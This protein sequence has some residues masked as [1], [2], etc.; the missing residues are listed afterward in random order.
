M[1]LV[2]DR[3]FGLFPIQDCINVGIS[4]LGSISI[5]IAH[6]PQNFLT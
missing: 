6:Q 4:H 3:Y 1:F 2:K 5:R